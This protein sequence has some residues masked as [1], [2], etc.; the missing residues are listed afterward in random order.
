MTGPIGLNTGGRQLWNAVNA[1]HELAPWQWELLLEAC[2][3]KDRLDQLAPVAAAGDFAAMR[4]ERL[5][6]LGMARLLAALRLPDSNGRRPQRRS[7]S[8]GFYGA[9]PVDP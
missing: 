4:E 8:R 7:G 9:R 2:R 3:A 5:T 1:E 6:S